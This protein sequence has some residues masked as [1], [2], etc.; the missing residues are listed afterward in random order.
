MPIVES[1][2]G[3]EG[4]RELGVLRVEA[5]KEMEKLGGTFMCGSTTDSLISEHWRWPIQC[6]CQYKYAQDLFGQSSII[7]SSP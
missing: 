4:Y 7:M 5:I 2:E 6:G 3:G 1:D